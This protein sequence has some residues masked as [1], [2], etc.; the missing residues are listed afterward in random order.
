MV[1][2]FESIL[3]DSEGD[4]INGIIEKF[5]KLAALLR[6]RVYRAPGGTAVLAKEYELLASGNQKSEKPM[7]GKLILQKH[8]HI[9]KFADI[10]RLVKR[11]MQMW[12][13]DSLEELIQEAELCKR[14]FSTNATNISEEQAVQVFSRLVLQGKIKEAVR[15]KCFNYR[16]S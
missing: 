11:R 2:A 14:K 4:L 13:N 1:L 16:S 5:W 12:R 10:R 15:Y 6:G 9:N 7:L 8:K 3:T